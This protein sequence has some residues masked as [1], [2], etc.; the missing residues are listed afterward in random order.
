MPLALAGASTAAGFYAFLP[1]AYR[2]VSELGLIAGTGMIVAFVTSITLLPALLAVLRP[3]GANAR[4]S[5]LPAL[6]P[7][8]RFLTRRRFGVIAAAAVLAVASLLLRAEASVR[9]QPAEPEELARGI[10]GDAPRPDHGAR[11]RRPTR[12]RSWRRRSRGAVANWRRPLSA[13]PEVNRVVTLA[14]LHPGQQAA[15]AGGLATPRCC[16][17]P[18][19]IRSTSRR[20]RPTPKRC[21]PMRR[22]ARVLAQAAGAAPVERR[23]H[24]RARAGRG[25]ERRSPTRIRRH[26]SARGERRGPGLAVTLDTAARRAAGGARQRSRAC[27]RT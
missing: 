19:S 6:A 14:E 20:R 26:A 17:T 11:T 2:G 9:L 3:R 13:L 16:S 7:L 1:T 10:G 23:G 18:R 27:P 4:P 22:T 25:A 12:S 24:R 15:E 5:A 8:D 21:A